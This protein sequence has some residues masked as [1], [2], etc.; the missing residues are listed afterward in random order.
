MI[1]KIKVFNSSFVDSGFST[2]ESILKSKS[3]FYPYFF[4]IFSPAL[5]N[6]KCILTYK[7]YCKPSHESLV[8]LEKYQ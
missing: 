3:K 1:S 2:R 6:K 5:L 7:T 4:K 8:L